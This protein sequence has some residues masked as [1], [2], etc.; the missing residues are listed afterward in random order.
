MVDEVTA[1]DLVA[2]LKA[3]G[4]KRDRHANVVTHASLSAFGQL[5][6]GAF[7]LLQAVLSCV[8]T[9]VMPAFTY[10]TMVVPEYGPPDN[11]MAYGQ[12]AERNAQAETFHF[13]LPVYPDADGV[14]ETLRADG[15][16]LRSVHPVLSFAAY[17]RYAHDVLAAQTYDNPFGPIEWLEVS[18]GYALL[19]GAGQRDNFALHLAAQRAGRTGFVRWAVTPEGIEEL[20]NFPGC[21]DG[22]ETITPYLKDITRQ[23]EIGL[24]TVQ[25]IPLREM[26]AR[27][28]GLVAGDPY[29]LLCQR[30]TCERCRAREPR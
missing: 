9:L 12:A 6:G 17:G 26:L 15:G 7:A 10:Q 18:G 11:G 27:A 20:P 28:E 3:L 16:T 14:S 1:E 25:L 13:D 2:G 24:A 5:E 21:S 23:E 8:E 29:A 4:L 22:F 19:L 30:A